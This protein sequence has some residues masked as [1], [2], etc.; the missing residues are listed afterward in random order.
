M[1]L[2]DIKNSLK[3]YHT[4]THKLIETLKTFILELPEYSQIKPLSKKSRC[5]IIQFKDLNNNLSVEHYDFKKQYQLVVQELNSTE[6]IN[7]FKKL[8]KIIRSK[9]LYIATS[10]K[11]LRSSYTFNLHP[12][13]VKNLRK[14]YFSK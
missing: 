10:N 8:C 13:V 12:I 7:V 14:L 4:E 6:P 1:R 2:K 11:Q 9:K 5:F 3:N